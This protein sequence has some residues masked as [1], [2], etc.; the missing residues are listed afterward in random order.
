LYVNAKNR[1]KQ[2][3]ISFG[4]TSTARL[5]IMPLMFSAIWCT[6]VTAIKPVHTRAIVFAHFN[7]VVFQ[8]TLKLYIKM[9]RNRWEVAVLVLSKV[10]CRRLSG[11]SDVTC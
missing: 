8:T 7:K 9:H 6:V 1:Q 2:V 5:F 10:L 11:R 4:I 3:D